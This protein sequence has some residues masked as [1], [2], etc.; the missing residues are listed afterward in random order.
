MADPSDAWENRIEASQ[1]NAKGCKFYLADRLSGALIVNR[2]ANRIR[3]RAGMELLLRLKMPAACLAHSLQNKCSHARGPQ[4]QVTA[5]KNGRA[6]Q[7]RL[8]QEH[9]QTGWHK[10]QALTILFTRQ[11]AEMVA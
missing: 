2:I 6:W 8:A 1:C 3:H 7:N 4:P 9:G 5:D 11:A 10:R